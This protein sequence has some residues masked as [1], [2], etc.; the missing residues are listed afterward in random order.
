MFKGIRNSRMY[1]RRD[2]RSCL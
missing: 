1:L 2:S